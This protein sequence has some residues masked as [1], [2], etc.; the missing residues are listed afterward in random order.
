[1][2]DLHTYLHRHTHARAHKHTH[3]DTVRGYPIYFPFSRKAKG[4]LSIR[5]Q[6]KAPHSHLASTPDSGAMAPSLL[7][8]RVASKTPELYWAIG[9]F[10]L[11]PSSPSKPTECLQPLTLPKTLYSV[12]PGLGPPYAL[13]VLP[14]VKACGSSTTSLGQSIMTM[15]VTELAQA[16]QADAALTEC[17]MSTML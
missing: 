14:S 10:S 4:P 11:Q 17:M 9:S 13:P 12:V 5:L 16:R 6:T 15:D 3:L 1:M 7:H 8:L 2:T